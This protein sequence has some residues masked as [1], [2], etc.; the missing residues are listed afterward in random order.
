ME[1]SSKNNLSRRDFIKTSAVSLAAIGAGQS[2]VFAAGSDKIRVGL[3]GCGG[4]GTK[5][6]MNCVHSAPGV[7]ITAMGDVL[8]DR[9]NKSLAKMSMLIDNNVSVTQDTAFLGFDAYQKVI[10]SDVHIGDASSF[11]PGPCQ[12]GGRGRKA[13]FCGKTRC[14]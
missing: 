1:N 4:R 10:N 8:Q 3:I 2:R 14:C 13:C 11:S 6:A 7:E 9:L 12:G 5:A